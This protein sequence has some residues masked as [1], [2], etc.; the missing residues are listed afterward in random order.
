[1]YFPLQDLDVARRIL[2]NPGW[3]KDDDSI[4]VDWDGTATKQPNRPPGG[5]RKESLFE[6]LVIRVLKFNS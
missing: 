6:F 4:V 3:D 5:A 2:A 1:M